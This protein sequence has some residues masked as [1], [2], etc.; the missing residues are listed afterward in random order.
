MSLTSDGFSWPCGWYRDKRW[1]RHDPTCTITL[2]QMLR[3]IMY[4]LTPNFHHHLTLWG[5]QPWDLLCWIYLWGQVYHA[6]MHV[7]EVYS[8]K[9][10]RCSGPCDPGNGQ[11]LGELFVS[12]DSPSQER[13]SWGRARIDSVKNEGPR[14]STCRWNQNQAQE[15]PLGTN[16]MK[17]YSLLGSHQVFLFSLL[18]G[19]EY[20]VQNIAIYTVHQERGTG[21][22]N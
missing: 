3:L 15:G 7:C 17:V 19:W 10:T 13:Q 1:T 14:C 21:E 16:E 22:S 12:V 18:G 4:E 6:R 11:G 2:S 5:L 9:F 8:C 20:G